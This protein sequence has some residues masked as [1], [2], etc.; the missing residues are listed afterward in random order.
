MIIIMLFNSSSLVPSLRR[1]QKDLELHFAW[2][3]RCGLGYRIS[4]LASYRISRCGG[5][6]EYAHLLWPTSSPTWT[7][8]RYYLVKC[9]GSRSSVGFSKFKK[10]W[11]SSNP[12]CWPNSFYP[13]NRSTWHGIII[14]LIRSDP[15]MFKYMHS[16]IY[17]DIYVQSCFQSLRPNKTKLARMYPAKVWSSN[18]NCL[19]K[20]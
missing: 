9:T 7:P 2:R 17:M 3:E 6:I 15:Q 13:L 11:N 18:V 20:S 5:K 12:L 1:L 4:Q 10:Y 16:N 14:H 19:T 8:G